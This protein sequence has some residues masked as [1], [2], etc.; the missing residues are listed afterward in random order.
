MVFMVYFI[1]KQY[2]S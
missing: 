2:I 1:L